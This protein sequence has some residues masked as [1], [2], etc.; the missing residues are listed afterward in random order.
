MTDRTDAIASIVHQAGWLDEDSDEQAVYLLT[1]LL[2]VMES[3]V[4]QVKA[5]PENRRNLIHANL[6]AF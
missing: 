5:I 4:A 3:L 2:P 1:N 6:T